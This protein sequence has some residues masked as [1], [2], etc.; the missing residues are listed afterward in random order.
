MILFLRNTK[1]RTTKVV[2]FVVFFDVY[3]WNIV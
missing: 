1:Y 2:A 3:C